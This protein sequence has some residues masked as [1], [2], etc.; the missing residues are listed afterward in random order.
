MIRDKRNSLEAFIYEQLIGP[1]GCG[2]NFGVFV[3]DENDEE[4][5]C[6]VLNTTPGSIYSTGILFPRKDNQSLLMSDQQSEMKN[7]EESLGD[8]NLSDEESD[9]QGDDMRDLGNREE[10]EDINSLSRRFPDRIGISCCVRNIKSL[11]SGTKITISGRY[12]RKLSEKT[13]LYVNIEDSVFFEKAYSIDKCKDLFAPYFRYQD[14]K[15]SLS[16]VISNA[17]DLKNYRDKMRD[18]NKY[19]CAIVAKNPN[20]EYDSIYTDRSFQDKNKFLSAYK[21]RLFKSLKYVDREGKYLSPDKVAEYKD[22]IA[23]IEQYE[24][25]N[26]HCSHWPV[27]GILR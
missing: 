21:E 8:E 16:K 25:Y 13:C 7:E 20:G 18:L 14:K 11:T 27:N 3:N 10:D 17:Q 19:F 26:Q 23:K 4:T 22:R 6:E 2:N 12:Y 9:E 15:L 1:G 5:V 24:T